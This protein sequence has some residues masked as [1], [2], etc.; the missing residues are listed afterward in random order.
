MLK[1]GQYIEFLVPLPKKQCSVLAFAPE[2]M[3]VMIEIVAD[4]QIVEHQIVMTAGLGEIAFPLPSG[5]GHLYVRIVN[6]SSKA[7]LYVL[8]SKLPNR[9]K[10]KLGDLYAE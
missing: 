2:P 10:K 1:I 5:F 9:I 3:D 8:Q 7:G 6:M 4:N